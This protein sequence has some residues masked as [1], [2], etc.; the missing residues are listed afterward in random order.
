MWPC[1]LSEACGYVTV[2]LDLDNFELVAL[3]G[4]SKCHVSIQ[5]QRGDSEPTLPTSN[6]K[7]LFQVSQAT[8]YE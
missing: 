7:H 5:G 8:N 3:P 4:S 2:L 6:L 1:S